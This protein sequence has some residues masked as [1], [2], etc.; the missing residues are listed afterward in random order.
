MGSEPP[1][2]PLDL[3][4]FD[5]LLIGSRSRSFVEQVA[6]ITANRVKMPKINQTELK[7]IWIA[8]PEQV[9][10]QTII[11]KYLSKKCNEIDSIIAEKR[12]IISDLEQYKRSLIFELVT[13]KRKVV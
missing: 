8:L 10:E 1:Q 4:F 2:K 6:A 9:S 13:G 3:I 12:S 5:Y 11:A 7:Q